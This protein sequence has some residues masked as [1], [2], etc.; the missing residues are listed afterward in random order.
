MILAAVA[1]FGLS[2]LGAASGP[3]STVLWFILLGLGL[4]TAILGS[5]MSAKVASVLPARW[6]AA[7]LPSLTPAQLGEV[8]SLVSVG[9]APVRPGIPAEIASL[10]TRISHDTFTSGMN[11][12]FLTAAVVALAG[13]V[14]ALFSRPAAEHVEP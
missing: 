9:A 8:K 12:A 2:R 3:G 4:G 13:A 11:A 7:H 10:I 1:L 5:V 14:V 6:S